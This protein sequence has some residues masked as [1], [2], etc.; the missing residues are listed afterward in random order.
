VAQTR[1]I[2]YFRVSDQKQG[3]SG[4]G[5]EAQHAAVEEFLHQNNGRLLT[6]YREVEHGDDAERPQLLKAVNDCKLRNAILLVAKVDRLSRDIH[7]LTSLQKAG[8]RFRAADM[9]DANELVVHILIAVAQHE[10]QIIRGR[11]KSALQAVQARI[12][13]ANRLG[14]PLT[15]KKEAPLVR[16]GNPAGLTAEAQAKGAEAARKAKQAMLAD[17]LALLKPAIEEIQAAGHTSLNAIAQE[18]GAREIDAPR[19]GLGRQ[20]GCL[21]CC[22]GSLH[23]SPAA[24]RGD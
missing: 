9:P 20:R 19:G 13:A 1:F 3:R 15:N 17:R 24:L 7:F 16:L 12:D 23:E 21:V 5:L 8:V 10:L 11:T 14:I 18:L 4:L 2:A 22:R 6:S